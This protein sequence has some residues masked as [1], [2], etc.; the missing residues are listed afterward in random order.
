VKISN[1]TKVG[2]IA[3]VSVALLILGFSFLKGKKLWSRSTTL[4]AVYGNIEG[5]QKSNPVLINGLQV[6]SV[7]DIRTDKEMRNILVELT[8]TKDVFIPNNSVC[9]IKTNPLATPT[10]EIK[11][12]DATTHLKNRDSIHTEPSGGF[13]DNMMKN[14]DPVLTDVKK[15]IKS[16]DALLLNFNSI[17]DPTAKKNIGASFEHLNAITASMIISTASLEKLLNTQ[18]GALAKSLNNVSAITENF[19]ASNKNV[20]NVMSNLDKTT[21]KMASLELE[22]TISSLN[23]TLADLQGMVKKINSADGTV[24]KLIN[25]PVMYNNLSATSNKLNLL[26]DD[27]RINPKRYVNISVFGKKQQAD[28]LMVPLP[29]TINAPYYNKK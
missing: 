9:I 2:A 22:K 19:A 16:L 12:G 10:M 7:Y 29:D 6:G 17:L 18:T 28:A 13:L 27:I 3:L 11:L 23:T 25:D 1:E 21:A 15:S 5:L 20:T 4:Y 26:L 8:I 24:G 14:V